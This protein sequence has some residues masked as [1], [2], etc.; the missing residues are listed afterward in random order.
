MVVFDFFL[1]VMIF[2]LSGLFLPVS[3][4]CDSRLFLGF[5][6]VVFVGLGFP[7]WFQGFVG[8]AERFFGCLFLYRLI[9]GRFFQGHRMILFVIIFLVPHNIVMGFSLGFVQR[10]SR[11][12]CCWV[13]YKY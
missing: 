8:F 6:W 13:F 3:L 2:R 11:F 5:F 12:C 4:G 10:S 1:G 7:G 9:F